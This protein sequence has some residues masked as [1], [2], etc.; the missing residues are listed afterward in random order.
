MG[1]KWRRYYALLKA[2]NIL[3]P[4]QE[5]SWPDGLRHSMNYISLS[6]KDEY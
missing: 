3:T 1:S 6:C 2:L 4:A 5:D